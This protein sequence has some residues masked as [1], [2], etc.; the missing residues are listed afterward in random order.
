MNVGVWILF[1]KG[2]TH[3]PVLLEIDRGTAYQQR[4]KEHVKSRIEFIRSGEYQ[5]LFDSKGCVIA[6]M[7][8]GELPEYKQSRCN[9]MRLWTMETLKEMNLKSWASIFLFSSVVRKDMYDTPLFDGLVWMRPD[10]DS[11][12]GLLTD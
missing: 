11:P 9:T 12:L 5:K 4:F 2:N 3:Y 1:K 8:T 7:T 6:Y 10:S